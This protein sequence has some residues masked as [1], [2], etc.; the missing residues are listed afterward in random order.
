MTIDQSLHSARN[1]ILQQ[2]EKVF[3]VVGVAVE[4]ATDVAAV[5]VVFV[6]VF[7]LF[8]VLAV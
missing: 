6:V 5:V 3:H 1:W 7:S 8:S 2:R 4:A